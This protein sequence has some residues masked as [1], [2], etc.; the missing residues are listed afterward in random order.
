MPPRDLVQ[1]NIIKSFGR[2]HAVYLFLKFHKQPSQV[3]P[4][5]KS[6][7]EKVVTSASKQASIT[8]AWRDNGSRSPAP[9]GVGMFGLSA[10]GYKYL[11]CGKAYPDSEEFGSNRFKAGLKNVGQSDGAYLWDP[12]VISWEPAYKTDGI[13]AFV[14]L[15]DDDAARLK[16]TVKEVQDALAATASIVKQ[17]N[18]NVVKPRGKDYGVETFGFREAIAKVQEPESVFTQEPGGGYGCF[19]SFLKLKQNAKKFR[20]DSAKIAA[21]ARKQG[22]SVTGPGVQALAI[23]RHPD[24]TPLVATARGNLNDFSF[25]GVSET[26]CPMH[27]HIRAMN[28]RNPELEP[29][30]KI[31]RRGMPYRARAGNGSDESESGLLFLSFQ[32]SILDF[33][34]LLIRSRARLDPVLTRSSRQAAAH[35]SEAGS[36]AASSPQQR[37]TFAATRKSV[38]AAAAVETTYSMA[39]LTTIKGG[40]YFYIPSMTFI[41]NL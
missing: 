12:D 10:S 19:A 8:K 5:L 41:S 22:A 31:L 39:D 34:G 7:L 16:K 23:G 26:V 14:L 17:E 18:A 20:D 15:A 2:P 13:H 27:A 28:P 35:V 25:K 24:G 3:R 38:G 33:L 4:A 30:F 9:S 1:G 32:K 6:I 21:D 11:D 29:T 36:V 37:W 40:E